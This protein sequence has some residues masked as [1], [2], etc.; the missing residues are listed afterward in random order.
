[1]IEWRV[2]TKAAAQKV[3]PDSETVMRLVAPL[4]LALIRALAPYRLDPLLIVVLHSALG[5]LAALLIA[6]ASYPLWLLAALLLLVKTV[7]DNVDGGLARATGQVTVMGRYLDTVL[8]TLVNLALFLA[9]AAHGSL[10]VSL[11]AYGLLIL[12]L[13][14]RFNAQRLYREARQEGEPPG[15]HAK[16]GA[17]GWLIAP[18]RG[19]Y[20]LVLAPQD[21]LLER[22]DRAIFAR[23]SGKQP[24]DAPE[25]WRLVWNGMIS[26]APL[27]NLG[28]STQLVGLSLFLL[29]GLPYGYVISLFV[30]ALYVL[31]VQLARALSF[32]RYLRQRG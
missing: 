22:L 31:L 4:A 25:G 19:F 3:R 1:V 27:V 28:L 13:S 2:P 15:Q 14:L 7:L 5:L 21:R 17:P 32:R 12:I 8:D 20:G 29:I 18:F 9:L 24:T 11:V 23:L 30:Q 6:R 26:T 16:A 10:L